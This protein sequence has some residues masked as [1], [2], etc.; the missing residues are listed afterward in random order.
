MEYKVT[1]KSGREEIVEKS[2]LPKF[3]AN[4]NRMIKELRIGEKMYE[5]TE[6]IDIERIK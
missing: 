6:M 1:Y 3:S 4:F 5:I 2:K